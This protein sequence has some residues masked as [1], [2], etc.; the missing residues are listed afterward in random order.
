MYMQE[1]PKEGSQRGASREGSQKGGAS[2]QP[3]SQYKGVQ[4]LDVRALIETDGRQS[5]ELENGRPAFVSSIPNQ[6]RGAQTAAGW[7][8]WL[9]NVAG[10]ALNGLVPRKF[11]SFEKMTKVN[12]KVMHSMRF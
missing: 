8:T 11:D 6:A 9:T 4:K 7:P 1:P 10:E 12:D 2:T 5:H 3:G